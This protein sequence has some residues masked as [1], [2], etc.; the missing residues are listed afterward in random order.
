MYQQ[1]RFARTGMLF[2][3]KHQFRSKVLQ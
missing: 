2:G 1:R 3:Q